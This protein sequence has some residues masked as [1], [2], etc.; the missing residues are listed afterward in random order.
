M[1]S[2]WIRDALRPPQRGDCR[3]MST[4]WN[5]TWRA[6]AQGVGVGGRLTQAFSQFSAILDN[7]L[8][9]LLCAAKPT[10]SKDRPPLSGEKRNYRN[11]DQ[12]LFWIFTEVAYIVVIVINHRDICSASV[13]VMDCSHRRRGR[14]KTV[15]SL[16]VGGVNNPLDVYAKVAE[17]MFSSPEETFDSLLRLTVT[18]RDF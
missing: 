6:Q 14:D 9:Q 18:F 8:W 5:G 7:Q 1:S 12:S 11:R 10:Q 16:R 15:L 4:A 3:R 13:T 2:V 17:H